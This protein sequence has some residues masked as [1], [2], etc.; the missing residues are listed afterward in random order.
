[1]GRN[2]KRSGIGS[3]VLPPI[4]PVVVQ[5]SLVTQPT[6]PLSTKLKDVPLIDPRTLD[7]VPGQPIGVHHVSSTNAAREIV[8]EGRIAPLH[9]GEKYNTGNVGVF[10][11][12]TGGYVSFEGDYRTTNYYREM[13]YDDNK[14]T[15]ATITPQKPIVLRDVTAATGTRSLDDIARI[16]MTSAQR[17]SELLPESERAL[18]DS[19]VEP[20]IDRFRI[21]S[22]DLEEMETERR[23]LSLDERM[24]P[25]N[26]NKYNAAV[27]DVRRK[28]SAIAQATLR[29]LKKLGYDALVILQPENTFSSIVGGNQILILI[30]QSRWCMECDHI[31][32]SND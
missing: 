3:V 9:R 1:M 17:I 28:S 24:K 18:F 10:G 19:I 20:A 16:R 26:A 12:P 32:D 31:V 7:I 25:K 21:S 14:I 2:R 13:R 30:R 8:R 6:T 11:N 4:P 22:F 5:R 27:S 29:A 23:S 15:S